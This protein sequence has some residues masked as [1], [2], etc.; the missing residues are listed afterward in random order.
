MATALRAH[1]GFRPAL[2]PP[3]RSPGFAGASR[4]PPAAFRTAL[5][6]LPNSPLL[7]CSLLESPR[8]RPFLLCS[9]P[10]AAQASPAPPGCRRAGGGTAAQP[11]AGP[12][13]RRSP[14]ACAQRQAGQR[15]AYQLVSHQLPIV[16]IVFCLN[17]GLPMA[18]LLFRGAGHS[19]HPDQPTV[20]VRMWGQGLRGRRVAS[21]RA[22]AADRRTDACMHQLPTIQS[23]T[24]PPG[25]QPLR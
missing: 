3:G 9:P 21:R 17:F 19:A 18:F 11:G 13:S 4:H 25:P 5:T 10:V 12:A 24:L 23:C 2:A 7:S 22:L 8:V 1:L 20:S 16:C 14:A 15:E 6:C